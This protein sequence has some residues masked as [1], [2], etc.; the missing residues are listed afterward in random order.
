MKNIFVSSTFRD[1]QYERDC[2]RNQVI[3]ALNETARKYGE[4][5]DFCDLRWGV[6]T[7][8]EYEKAAEKV[9]SVC[10][11]EID[12]SRPYMLILLG[13]RYGFVPDPSVISREARKRKL[14]LEEMEI[15]VTQLE[16]E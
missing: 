2:L 12:R 11:D 9:I 5:V 6:D 4:S 14:E 3:P 7:T 15:S 10:L 8:E 13:E 1:F 16:I